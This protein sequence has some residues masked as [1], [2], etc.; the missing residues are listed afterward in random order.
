MLLELCSTPP[1][2]QYRAAPWGVQASRFAALG[3]HFPLCSMAVVTVQ[4]WHM[5]VP[6]Q[7]CHCPQPSGSPVRMQERWWWSPSPT[8][9]PAGSCPVS[10]SWLRPFLSLEAP[11]DTWPPV[12]CSVSSSSRL[13]L[14]RPVDFSLFLKNKKK[15]SQL[16]L[17]EA[18]C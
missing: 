2:Q 16:H 5:V 3:F 11:P 12:L 18:D 4:S 17:A 6:L 9:L 8:P 14:L 15:C 10:L 1:V 7:D 13:K